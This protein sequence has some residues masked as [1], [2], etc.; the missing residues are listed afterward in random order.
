M[1]E[2]ALEPEGFIE[3]VARF[4]GQVSIDMDLMKKAV[5]EIDAKQAATW[6]DDGMHWMDMG[7][8]GEASLPSAAD[9]RDGAWQ[10]SFQLACVHRMPPPVRVY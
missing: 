5:N 10:A 9:G 1:S 2:E 7:E 8:G 3:T 6:C 4:Y